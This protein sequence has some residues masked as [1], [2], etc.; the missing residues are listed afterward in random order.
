MDNPWNSPKPG[1]NPGQEQKMGHSYV[2]QRAFVTQIYD[3]LGIIWSQVRNP[4]PVLRNNFH[5]VSEC[6]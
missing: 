6:S 5:R 1:N 3:T 2:D 4:Q